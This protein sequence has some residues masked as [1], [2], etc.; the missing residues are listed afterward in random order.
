MH[1]DHI[2]IRASADLLAQVRDFY[3]QVLDLTEGFRPD[4]KSRGYWLYRAD[5][6]I[7][8]LSESRQDRKA[9]DTGCLD[10]I[11]L[12]VSDLNPTLEKLDRLGIEYQTVEVPQ[13]HMTQLFFSDP[14][15]IRIELNSIAE[16]SQA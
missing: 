8:H 3:C 1:I 7:V 4:F 11:A 5:H 12:R 2:N 6:P 13:L 9:A 16:V 14:A 10:H 15:G